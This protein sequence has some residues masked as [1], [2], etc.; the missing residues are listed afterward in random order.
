MSPTRAMQAVV[1]VVAPTWPLLVRSSS[2]NDEETDC[3][4]ELRMYKQQYYFIHRLPKRHNRAA[5]TTE[6]DR[7][8]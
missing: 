3:F 5:P 7:L 2:A 4:V 8:D 1:V 6:V